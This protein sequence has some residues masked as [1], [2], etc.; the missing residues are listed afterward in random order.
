ME[1]PL[2]E[3]SIID[4]CTSRNTWLN[5]MD[6]KEVLWQ[7]QEVGYIFKSEGENEEERQWVG[8]F[9]WYGYICLLVGGVLGQTLQ[10]IIITEIFFGQ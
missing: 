5:Y 3:N 6:C 2:T 4:I 8:R 10:M 1:I 9:D 7:L